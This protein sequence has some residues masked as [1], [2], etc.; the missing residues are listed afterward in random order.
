MRG[1]RCRAGGTPDGSKSALR[2]ISISISQEAGFSVVGENQTAGF[3]DSALILPCGG[4]P[5]QKNF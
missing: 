2:D 1:L 3:T 5:P 4:S